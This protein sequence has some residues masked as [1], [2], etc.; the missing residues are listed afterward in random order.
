MIDILRQSAS[1]CAR[2]NREL[3]DQEFDPGI[4]RRVF[5]TLSDDDAKAKFGEFNK[6][7]PYLRT[8]KAPS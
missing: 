6:I 5:E 8:T 4:V 7:L 3:A 1:I 2:H